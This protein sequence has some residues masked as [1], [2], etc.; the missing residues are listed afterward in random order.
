M[1]SLPST[2]DPIFVLI[3]ANRFDKSDFH[4]KPTATQGYLREIK[5]T[6]NA[7][8]KYVK[9]KY[10]KTENHINQYILKDEIGR[11][12]YGAVHYAVDQSKTEYA[13]KVVSKSRL[14]RRS[15]SLILKKP[16]HDRV[17]SMP[18][19][20]IHKMNQQ[21]TAQKIHQAQQLQNPLY[22]VK[23]EMEVMKRTNHPNI[24]QL[25]EVLDD[26]EED[27]LYMVLEPCMKDVVTKVGIGEKADPQSPE[28]CRKW[29]RQIICGLEHLHEQGII[30]RDIKPDNLLLTKDNILKIAD[31]GDSEVFE[32]GSDMMIFKSAGSPAFTPPELCVKNHGYVSGTAADIWSLGVSLY[33]M[34][35]GYLPF[36]RFG[37]LELYDAITSDEIKLDVDPSQEPEFHDLMMRL[38]QKDPEK[39]AN[40][41]Q[42]KVHPWFTNDCSEPLPK[43]AMHVSEELIKAQAI[44]IDKLSNNPAFKDQP[45]AREVKEEFPSLI[46]GPIR[47]GATLNY[48]NQSHETS[49]DEQE[50]KSQIT[51]SR[52]ILQCPIHKY[53][54]QRID[55]G[56][57]MDD[58]KCE[59]SNNSHTGCPR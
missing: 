1:L 47:S 20:S 13:I 45:F 53:S 27:S 19:P 51:A 23:G 16:Q 44:K 3:T 38:L 49:Y 15:Q 12:S 28:K 52:K 50:P 46:F 58:F 59:H 4:Q 10:G 17:E 41:E 24:L 36:E 21:C 31:F 14:R 57:S 56:I 18:W 32:K 9:N 35:F 5:E 8:S 29:F 30:H 37:I 55:S 39:R 34:R 25:I 7:S 40:I 22:L 43:S 11:G 2:K 48:N 6:L 33:C 42:I 26:P 54:R